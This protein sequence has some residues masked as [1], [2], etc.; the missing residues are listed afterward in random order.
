MKAGASILNLCTLGDKTIEEEL[1]KVLKS[2]KDIEKGIAFP[3]CVSRNN[4]VGHYSAEVGDK[5]TLE[6]GDLVKMYAF[7]CDFALLSS[8]SIIIVILEHMLMD[9]FLLEHTHTL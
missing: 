2:Q 4:I 9:L 7:M 1:K 8:N 5:E 6:E 3:T